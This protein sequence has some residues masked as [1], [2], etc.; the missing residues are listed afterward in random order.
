MEYSFYLSGFYSDR[1][2]KSL[3]DST[4]LDRDTYEV[5]KVFRGRKVKYYLSKAT[6]PFT[7]LLNGEMPEIFLFLGD[8][9]KTFFN[10]IELIFKC[11]EYSDVV[12]QLTPYEYIGV[13]HG[14]LSD[15][16]GH[17]LAYKKIS[18]KD[19]YL[20][21]YKELGV[22]KYN[23]Y[24][25]DNTINTI[26]R[27]ENL[28]VLLDYADHLLYEISHFKIDLSKMQKSKKYIEYENS[29]LSPKFKHALAVGGMFVVKG[30]VKLAA[31][32]IGGDINIDGDF[33]L[34]D[35]DG[36]II[37]S[38]DFDF[39]NGLDLN[40]DL[41]IDGA[42]AEWYSAINGD[43]YSGLTFEGKHYDGFEDLNKTIT[44]P[45]MGGGGNDTLHVY[46]KIGSNTIYVT[47][48]SC[49]PVSISGHEWIKV[50]SHNFKVSNI[51]SKL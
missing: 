8:K 43:S 33:D 51:K 14:V 10:Q 6:G 41:D 44:V 39:G 36:D 9:V 25:K 20:H 3:V 29:T 37:I 21:Y 32:S 47:D 31:K 7:R 42:D 17:T 28:E 35:F 19:G 50:G 11:F 45:V 26:D 34:P 40:L 24:G 30:A 16:V 15:Y 1:D 23:I 49:Y 12:R 5:R 18:R 48:G 27:T 13:T 46:K 2:S 4:F 38:D 22:L